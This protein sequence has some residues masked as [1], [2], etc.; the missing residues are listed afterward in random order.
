VRRATVTSGPTRERTK[1]ARGARLTT[2]PALAAT[3]RRPIEKDPGHMNQI[4]AQR[5]SRC[6]DC[7]S[8][9]QPGDM[10]TR[11]NAFADWRHVVCPPTKFDFDPSNVCPDCFT[12]RATTGACAC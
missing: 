2:F 6:P 3:A 1:V 11:G 8:F 9:I 12:V 7:D 10:I 4:E 5:P